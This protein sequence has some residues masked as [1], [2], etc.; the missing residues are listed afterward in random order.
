LPVNRPLETD[1]EPGGVIGGRIEIGCGSDARIAATMLAWVLPANARLPVDISYNT[2][3][4][5]ECRRRHQSLH[6]REQVEAE[7]ERTRLSGID[8]AETSSTTE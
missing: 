5:A 6:G 2:S 3:P 7:I 8:R 4:S 1:P